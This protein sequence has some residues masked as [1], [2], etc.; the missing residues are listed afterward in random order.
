MKI[1]DIPPTNRL[2]DW[3]ILNHLKKALERKAV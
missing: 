2:R 3:V 1:D